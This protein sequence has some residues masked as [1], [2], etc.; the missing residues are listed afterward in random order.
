[1]IC[2]KCLKKMK[3]V[4]HFEKDKSYMYHQCKKCNINTH[5]KRIHYDEHLKLII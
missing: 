1:M 2:P 5:K 3:N 4:I